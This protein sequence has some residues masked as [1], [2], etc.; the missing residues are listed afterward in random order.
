MTQTLFV[1]LVQRLGYEFSEGESVDMIQLRMIAIS[2]AST[3]RDPSVIQDLRNR[4]AEYMK[5]GDES[6][7]PPNIKQTVLVAAARFG[8]K[9]EFEALLKII[10]ESS[11]PAL[12]NAAVGSIGCTEDP[13]LVQE[14]FSYILTKARDQDVNRLCM[15]VKSSPVGLRMLA[16]F[17]KDNYDAFS[18]RFATNSNLPYFVAT[19]FNGLSTQADYNDIQEFFKDKDTSRYSMALAQTLE[20]IRVRVNYIERSTPDLL[21]WLTK[22]KQRSKD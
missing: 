8:G 2:G 5:T 22:W 9:N 17:F 14:L 12:K 13:G 1:P 7:I 18:K 3:G 21:D 20:T 11:N 10:E 6:K 4:F 19:C 15:G 16:N